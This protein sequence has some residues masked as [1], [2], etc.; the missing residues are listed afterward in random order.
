MNRK[1]RM[2]KRTETNMR[3]SC[4][5][6][7]GRELDNGVKGKYNVVNGKLRELV[8]RRGGWRKGKVISEKIRDNPV[9]EQ[10]W[11]IDRNTIRR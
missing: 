11:K 9:W 5:N 3:D 6:N 4:C 8:S 7:L 10:I 1:A 2:R